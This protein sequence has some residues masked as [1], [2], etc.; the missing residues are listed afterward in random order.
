M[1]P[2]RRNS[3]SATPNEPDDENES[4]DDVT[5]PTPPSRPPTGRTVGAQKESEQKTSRTR[6][7]RRGGKKRAHEAVNGYVNETKKDAR[8]R[9]G[10]HHFSEGNVRTCAQDGLINGAEQLGVEVVKKVVYDATLPPEGDTKV[11]TIV[12]FAKRSLGI[13]IAT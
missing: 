12:D 9:D 4:E 3:E 2:Q 6:G 8:T 11:E 7:K 10:S 5:T 13:T 1:G